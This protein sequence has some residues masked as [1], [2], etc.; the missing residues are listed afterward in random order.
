MTDLAKWEPIDTAPKDGTPF[1]AY[2]MR[3]RDNGVRFEAF[4]PYVICHIFGGRL[5][6]KTSPHTGPQP[7][8]RC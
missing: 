2:W 3:H 7:S 8:L 5:L 4:Q 1:V 6:K